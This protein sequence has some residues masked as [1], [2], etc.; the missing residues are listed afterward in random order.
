MLAR[1]RASGATV[2]PQYAGDSNVARGRDAEQD[3]VDEDD[4]FFTEEDIAGE[5]E[6]SDPSTLAAQKQGSTSPK[7]LAE[8]EASRRIDPVAAFEELLR[9]KGVNG[10]SRYEREL[11]KLQ[12]DPRFKSL[13]A[14]QRRQIFEKYC[15]RAGQEAKKRADHPVTARSVAARSAEEKLAEDAFRALLQEC[16]TRSSV[17]WKHVEGEL[18]KD[19]RA[20]GVPAERRESLF[21]AHRGVLQRV[22]DARERA[23]RRAKYEMHAAEERQRHAGEA[24]ALMNFRTL[25]AE[26]VHDA[27]ESWTE[28]L[29]RLQQDPQ[30]RALHPLL[31]KLA[32]ENLFREHVAKLEKLE[33]RNGDA[34]LERESKRARTDG[35]G[36]L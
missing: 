20:T 18:L 11:P 21:L 12:P 23:D 17:S 24:D 9:E 34:E 32:A 10:F 7:A 30:G 25:L 15:A 1:A 35:V 33:N 31:D 5:E 36:N 13:P 8:A 22:E 2:A 26:A 14:S 27:R 29:P 16:V 19:P 6:K 4:V 28:C 3:D